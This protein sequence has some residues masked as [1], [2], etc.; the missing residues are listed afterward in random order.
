MGRLC[1]HLPCSEQDEEAAGYS[2]PT[3]NAIEQ[4]ADSVFSLVNKPD[5][6]VDFLWNRCGGSGL[7]VSPSPVGL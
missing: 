4:P 7:T 6:S 2:F 3:G 1:V 5:F